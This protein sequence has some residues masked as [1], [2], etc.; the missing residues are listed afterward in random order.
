[1]TNT[2]R[3][4]LTYLTL[5]DM[6]PLK[7]RQQVVRYHLSTKRNIS[8]TARYF[9]TKRDTVKR[10]LKKLD[11]NGYENLHDASRAPHSIPHKTPEEMEQLVI[12][13]RKRTNYGKK[14]LRK[15]ILRIHKKSIP[16]GTIR[17]I[18]ER[19]GLKKQKRKRSKNGQSKPLYDLDKLYP[20]SEWQ[21]DTKHIKDKK[22][23]P[24][25]VYAHLI[26]SNLPLFQWT[27]IDPLTKIRFMAYS[28][29]LCSAYGI[30]FFSLICMWLRAFGYQHQI[31]FQT[32]SGTT[33]F[34]GSCVRK[35]KAWNKY[36]SQYNA[37][38]DPVTFCHATKQAYVERSHRT[39][40]E[41]FYIPCLTRMNSNKDF[42]SYAQRWQT[43]YNCRREHSGNAMYGRTPLQK[44]KSTNLLISDQ[45]TLFPVFI[46]DDLSF[47]LKK[48][49]P[50]VVAHYRRIIN[51]SEDI[52]LPYR[53]CIFKPKSLN[54][55]S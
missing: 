28:H 50:Y 12:Q 43:F 55:P 41:E 9:S 37:S 53:N 46:L 27:A 23:L 13:E 25:D 47:C 39:D 45:V 18:F 16:E 34:A 35:I 52:I 10:I 51:F 6:N 48:L 40:D 44:L 31:H 26:N 15:E 17:H 2:T 4:S 30:L 38:F 22:A 29:K 24:P 32:D 36:L 42:I 3:S 20:L 19:N 21:T 33:D 1:M 8:K 14:R 54:F 5:R 7:A 49:D 11:K